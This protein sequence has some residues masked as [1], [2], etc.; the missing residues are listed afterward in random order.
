MEQKIK[1]DS[2]ELEAEQCSST[3]ATDKVYWQKGV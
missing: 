1:Q 3:G 2:E